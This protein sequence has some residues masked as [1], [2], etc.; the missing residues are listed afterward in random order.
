MK[1]NQTYRRLVDVDVLHDMCR[2]LGLEDAD[3][4]SSFTRADL[5]QRGAADRV[6]AASWYEDLKDS[7]LP[8]KRRLYVD[9]F[10]HGPFDPGSSHKNREYR[11]LV[12]LRQLLRLHGRRLTFT[13]HNC[14]SQKVLHYRIGEAGL[15]LRTG[16]FRVSMC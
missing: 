7:Y 13:E 11:L 9:P 12:L 16:A 5:R 2:C 10:E 15:Q 8:C 6:L 14:G 3:D 1:I 4:G